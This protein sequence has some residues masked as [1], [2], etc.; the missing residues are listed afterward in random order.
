MRFVS[1]TV[2]FDN[3]HSYIR[4]KK[5]HY[6]ITMDSPLTGKYDDDNNVGL[7]DGWKYVLNEKPVIK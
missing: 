3:T 2:I 5:L 1:D 6:S 7:Q 4:N